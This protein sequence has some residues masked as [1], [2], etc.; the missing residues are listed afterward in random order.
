MQKWQYLRASHW[1]KYPGEVVVSDGRRLAQDQCL[2]ILG[3]EGWELVLVVFCPTER[4]Q[5]GTLQYY[6]ELYF[7]RPK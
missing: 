4:D 5:N 3:E 1:K 2:T 6:H 7:K